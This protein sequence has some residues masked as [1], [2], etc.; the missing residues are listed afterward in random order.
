LDSPSSC[1]TRC[2][3]FGFLC[4]NSRPKFNFPATSTLLLPRSACLC[5][6][7]DPC[8]LHFIPEL[9]HCLQSA[10]HF[11]PSTVFVCLVLL[12]FIYSPARLPSSL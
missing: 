3:N 12:L 2:G 7:V 6:S 4:S 8:L 1:S 9:T 5:H 11:V 10:R